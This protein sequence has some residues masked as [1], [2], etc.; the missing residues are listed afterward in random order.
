MPSEDRAC[1]KVMCATDEHYLRYLPTMLNSLFTN[2]KRHVAVRVVHAGL[3][4]DAIQRCIDLFP[5]RDLRFLELDSSCLPPTPG[6]RYISRLAYARLFMPELEAWDRYVYLDVDL[7]VTADIGNLYDLPLDG[8]WL[9][10]VPE[11]QEQV[12]NSGVLLVDALAWRQHDVG[13]KCIEYKLRDMSKMADQPAINAVCAGNIKML[14]KSWNTLI[15][16][17]WGPPLEEQRKS[18]SGANIV[19]YVTGFK[20]WN[21]GRF[22]M[23]KEAYRLWKSYYIPSKQPID[24]KR[25][26]TLLSWQLINLAR[27]FIEGIRRRK[28]KRE[29]SEQ[30]GNHNP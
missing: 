9:A 19:H 28:K 30:E 21:T 15:C 11:N 10:A 12:V 1:I 6:R 22:L 4:P 8:L 18:L 5:G 14:P 25:Q 3:H 24:W 29:E 13:K 2:T 23:P 27:H 20:P 17:L 7:V 26:A 16:P